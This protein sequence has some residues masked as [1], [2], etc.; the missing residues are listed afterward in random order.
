MSVS[1][2][3]TDTGVDVRV[4]VDVRD[5]GVNLGVSLGVRLVVGFPSLTSL[6]CLRARVR[7]GSLMS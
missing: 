2:T 1:N 3:D 4:D 5:Q 6:D 7:S